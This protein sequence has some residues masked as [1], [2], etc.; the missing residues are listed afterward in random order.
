MPVVPLRK[1]KTAVGVI[2]L[3]DFDNRR[4]VPNAE[5]CRILADCRDL[6]AHRL[7]VSFT[8]MMDRLADGL[9]DKASYSGVLSKTALLLETRAVV[10]ANRA[11]IV[12][13]FE[14]GLRARIDRRLRR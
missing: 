12:S 8:S 10:Q 13:A 14:K 3:S 1:E 9:F 11:Y 2:K 6:T 7:L 4:A 5:Y